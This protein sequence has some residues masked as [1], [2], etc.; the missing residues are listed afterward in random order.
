MIQLN[1]TAPTLTLQQVE[2]LFIPI[3]GSNYDGLQ[4]EGPYLYVR[5]FEPVSGDVEQ[6]IRDSF[7]K[8]SNLPQLISI[9]SNPPFAE[10]TYRTKRNATQSIVSIE[11]DNYQNIDFLM[12]AERYVAGG[13]II[14]ENAVFGDYLTA[15]VIDIDGVIPSLYRAALCENWPTVALYVEKAWILASGDIMTKMEMDTYPLNAKISAGLY[16]RITYHAI[17]SGSTRRVAVNYYL[18]KKL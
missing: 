6:I 1:W 14:I 7:Y 9:N 5:T 13:L 8:A 3:L 10:P 11:P 16:L 12:T 2:G 17:N 15:E 4:T 18:T